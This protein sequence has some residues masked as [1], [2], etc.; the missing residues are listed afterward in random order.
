MRTTRLIKH[1]EKCIAFL[2]AIAK[3][4][5]MVIENQKDAAN[6]KDMGLWSNKKWFEERVRANQALVERLT[7]SYNRLTEKHAALIQLGNTLKAVG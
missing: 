6:M 2:E 7:S 5:K 1:H 3:A 4:E